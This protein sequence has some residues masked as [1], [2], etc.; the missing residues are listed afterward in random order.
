MLNK[1]LTN[2]FSFLVF[3]W[4]FIVI[5]AFSANVDEMHLSEKIHESDIVLVGVVYS[6]E[7]VPWNHPSYP[8]LMINHEVSKVKSQKIIFGNKNLREIRIRT[9]LAIAEM[10][11]D[12]CEIGASYLFFLKRFEG[13]DYFSFNGRY[14]V[15]A[16]VDNKVS[17][18]K[19][20]KNID[21]D[22]VI[23]QIELLKAKSV[24]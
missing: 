23:E 5:K 10:R 18:W 9:D 2:S 12:C 20:K 13:D 3:S 24:N 19:D 21:L 17:S 7:K 8:E 16:V 4:F 6:L 11:L 1:N 14:G 15:Y 22:R